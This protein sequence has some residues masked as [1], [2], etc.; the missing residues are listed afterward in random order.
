MKFIKEEIS[1]KEKTRYM[2]ALGR[3]EVVILYGLVDKALRY[4]PRSFQTSPIEHS[5]HN[6]AK[7][8]TKAIKLI[9]HS[10]TEIIP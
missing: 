7:E 5:L 3:S 4:M 8:M 10:E 9:P 1:G 6:M 2:L